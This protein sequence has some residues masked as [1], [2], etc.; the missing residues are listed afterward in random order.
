MDINDHV[1]NVRY[2]EW[3]LECFPLDFHKAHQLKELEINYMAEAVYGDSISASISETRIK[4]FSHCLFRSEDER[5][6]CRSKNSW[7]K[8]N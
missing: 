5:E 3:I 8:L 4:I 1:Y 2:I 7:Q 6:L